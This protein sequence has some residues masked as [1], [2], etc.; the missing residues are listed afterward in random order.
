MADYQQTLEKVF[1]FQKHDQETDLRN[2]NEH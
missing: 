2:T 1:F